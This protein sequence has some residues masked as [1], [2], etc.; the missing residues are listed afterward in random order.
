MKQTELIETGISPIGDGQA[1][2]EFICSQCGEKAGSTVFSNGTKYGEVTG[3]IIQDSTP[4]DGEICDCGCVF[5]HSP[6]ST[7]EQ[8]SKITG[9][10]R[11]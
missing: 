4:D 2:A 5:N 9:R 11:M 6:R 1:E 7:N 3:E 10:G 8:R